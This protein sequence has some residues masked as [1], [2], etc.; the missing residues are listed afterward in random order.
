M[1]SI[2][3][4]G[5][6]YFST[7]RDSTRSNSRALMGVRRLGLAVLTCCVV[8]RPLF[9]A[10]DADTGSGIVFVLIEFLCGVFL[11]LD[12][13]LGGRGPRPG[14]VTIAWLAVIAAGWLSAA[15]ASY[16]FPAKIMAWEWTAVAI[17]WLYS[18][19]QSWAWGPLPIA[20]LLFALAVAQSF[21]ACKQVVDEFPA[22]R[23][24]FRRR[25]P[26]L[27]EELRRM[28]IEPGSRAEETFKNRLLHSTEP[29]G[30]FGLANS[31]AGFL[32]LTLPVV[33]ANAYT[34]W[35]KSMSLIVRC[36]AAIALAL[37]CVTLLLTKSRSGYLGALFA[38][39]CLAGTHFSLRD[40]WSVNWRRSLIGLGCLALAVVLVAALGGLDR[41]IIGEAGKS[42]GYRLE[43]WQATRG[44]IAERPWFGVGFG[45]F[46]DYYLRYKLPFSSEEIADPHN[47]VLELW[48]CGGLIMMSAYLALATVPLAAIVTARGARAGKLLTENAVG[49]NEWNVVSA[50]GDL[51][52]GPATCASVRGGWSWSVFAGVCLAVAM[53]TAAAPSGALGW[54]GLLI[55]AFSAYLVSRALESAD[56]PTRRL[57]VAAIAAGA[58]GLHVNWLAAGGV[59]YPSLLLPTWA[60]LASVHVHG[61]WR[62]SPVGQWLLAAGAWAL[63]ASL[64]CFW[65]LPLR[66]R[67]QILDSLRTFDQASLEAQVEQCRRAAEAAPDEVTG[68]ERLAMLHAARMHVKGAREPRVDYQFAVQYWK[69]AVALAPRRSSGYRELGK[70]HARAFEL[71]VDPDGLVRAIEA[72]RRGVERYPNSAE[73][74][75]ELGDMLL[76]TGRREEAT[77]EFRR[78]LELDRTPHPDKKLSTAQRI[79]AKLIVGN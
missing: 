57:A 36:V 64:L 69:R 20:C 51:S 10:E 25:D 49:A 70:L 62:P 42:L 19:Q 50:G 71:S 72:M 16:S 7:M 4:G 66:T 45:N 2:R 6:V 52:Q 55:L 37:V 18:R 78:A 35:R 32:V 12:W 40:R 11:L 47:F 34:V 38:L 44:V 33:V 27:A 39:A 48:S 28:G 5:N 46:R 14:W 79:R 59:S 58:L 21:A 15:N 61:D 75:W 77:T 54:T 41:L 24:Q 8:V 67:D 3:H 65:V 60:A 63:V 76:K 9:P 74:R 30:S 56:L 29:Y 73:R 22:L 23:E 68:W 1:R 31:L 13:A 43:W 17:V 53:V 26:K